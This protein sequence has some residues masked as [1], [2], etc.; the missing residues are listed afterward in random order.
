MVFVLWVVG[1]L[2]TVAGLCEVCVLRFLV[3]W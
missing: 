1:F 2:L 3:G